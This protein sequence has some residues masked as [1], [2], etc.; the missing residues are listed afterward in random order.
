M[1]TIV[2]LPV[3]Q[4][5]ALKNLGERLNLPRAELVRRAVADYIA[6]NRPPPDDVAFGLWRDHPEEGL[7]YQERLR[8]EWDE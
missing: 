5:N 6:R 3:D 1:R 4:V 8:S 2:D 7:R